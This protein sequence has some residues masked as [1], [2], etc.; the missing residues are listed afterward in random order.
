MWPRPEPCN[1]AAL[2]LFTACKCGGESTVEQS[3]AAPV[4][5][6]RPEGTDRANFTLKGDDGV[7]GLY[8]PGDRYYAP[9]AD[10]PFTGPV[11]CRGCSTYEDRQLRS[12]GVLKDGRWEGKVILWFENGQKRS[13]SE[14][15]DGRPVGKSIEWYESG[16]KK[17]EGQYNADGWPDGKWTWWYEN[18]QKMMVEEASGMGEGSAGEPTCWQEDGQVRPCD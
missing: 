9:G 2:L 13:E 1:N 14:Y 8:R 16:Q 17:E 5:S 18:G 7:E 3:E 4:S 11:F 6:L 10:K 15:V 12:E